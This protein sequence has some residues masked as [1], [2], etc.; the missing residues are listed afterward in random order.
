M[1]SI[2][3]TYSD[4]KK[5]IKDPTALGQDLALD[6]IKAPLILFTIFAVLFFAA[7]GVL[8]FSG[9]LGGPYLF[10]KVVFWLLLIPALIGEFIAWTLLSSVRRM[11][12]TARKN[13]KR[14]EQVIDVTPEI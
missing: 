2:I 9:V 3:K 5:G 12:E 11:I 6:V 13:M 7:L 10:F 4:V 1:F 8:A 14:E